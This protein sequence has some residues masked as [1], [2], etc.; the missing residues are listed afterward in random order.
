[1]TLRYSERPQR[2]SARRERPKR[3][4]GLDDTMPLSEGRETLSAADPTS[5]LCPN[6]CCAWSALSLAPSLSRSL[7]LSLHPQTHLHRAPHSTFP[8]LMRPAT[9]AR[10]LIGYRVWGTG[11]FEA[12]SYL[13]LIDFV[14]HSTLGVGRIEKKKRKKVQE[15]HLS[16]A[17][18]TSHLCPPLPN[19]FRHLRLFRREIRG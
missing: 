8:R 17:D 15:A 12:G 2:Q 11:G 14:C 4:G 19:S 18:A 6:T 13:R 10:L 9:S 3:P 16:A 5:H 1:M 7:S